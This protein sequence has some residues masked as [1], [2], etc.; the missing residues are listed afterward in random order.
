MFT[1]AFNAVEGSAAP[2]NN[3]NALPAFDASCE[4]FGLAR[5]VVLQSIGRVRGHVDLSIDDMS[6]ERV[7]GH[8]RGGIL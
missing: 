5:H 4:Q 7:D 8:G 1:Q 3:H 2:A 6:L